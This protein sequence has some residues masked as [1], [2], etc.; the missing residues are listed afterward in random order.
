MRFYASHFYYT[1]ASL[2]E[3]YEKLIEYD[4]LYDS[5]HLF[6]MAI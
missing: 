4:V 6:E 5:L 1:T 2:N 3:K